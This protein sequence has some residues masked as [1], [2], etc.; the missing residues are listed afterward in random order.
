MLS[1]IFLLAASFRMAYLNRLLKQGNY[2]VYNV[3][4]KKGRVIYL[5]SIVS[6][7]QAITLIV[8]LLGAY[9]AEYVQ[10]NIMSIV[11]IVL[12]LSPLL[13]IIKITKTSYNI[14]FI[15]IVLQIIATLILYWIFKLSF[16]LNGVI[17]MA[18][19][20]LFLRNLIWERNLRYGDSKTK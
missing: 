10:L 14:V 5:V 8:L 17:S 18:V 19:T 15:L 2:E 9:N 11:S 12:G 6:I 3:E 7:L 4:R 16:N 1:F 13:F 20:G